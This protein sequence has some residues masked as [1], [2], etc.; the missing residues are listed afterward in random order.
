MQRICP[1]QIGKV[2]RQRSCR[3]CVSETLY[4][5]AIPAHLCTVFSSPT[6]SLLLEAFSV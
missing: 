5:L 3:N 4:S 2:F 6:Y 1:L